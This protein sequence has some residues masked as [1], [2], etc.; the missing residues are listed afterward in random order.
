MGCTYRMV[1]PDGGDCVP[2]G[3]RIGDLLYDAEK[4]SRGL[5]DRNNGFSEDLGA[6]VSHHSEFSIAGS[7][8]ESLNHQN[9]AIPLTVMNFP[10]L[11]QMADVDLPKKPQLSRNPSS[12]EQCRVCQQEKE[13]DLINLGCHC[14]GGLAEAHQSCINTW[15]NSRGSNK[16]EICQ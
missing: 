10:T 13:E 9:G 5:E 14:R 6:Q 3:V 11:G 8:G 1:A 15:F 12:Q 2:V 4:Q 16:C 7:E